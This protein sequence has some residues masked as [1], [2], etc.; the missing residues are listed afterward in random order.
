MLTS[1]ERTQVVDAFA[2]AI[3]VQEHRQLIGV[4]FSTE[5]PQILLSL[6]TGSS[7]P[8]TLATL[9]VETCL[10]SRWATDP[11]L[12]ALLLDY[13]V[14]ARGI[15]ALAVVLQRVRDRVD[16]N[17]SEYGSTWLIGRRPFFDRRTLRERVQR[18]IED[19]GRPILRV[20][21]V[22]DSFGRTYSR[23][24]LEHLEDR[25]TGAVRVVAVELGAGTGPSYRIDDLLDTVASQLGVADPLPPRVSS[26]H[27]RTAARWLLK[28]L[29]SRPGRWLLVLDGFGDKGLHPEVRETIEALAASVP[30]GQYRL[31]IRLVLLDYPYALPGTTPSDI[32]EDALTP[33]AQIGASDIGQ[34]LA[35]WDADRKRLGREGMS[36]GDLVK[37]ATGLLES[38]PAAGR[39]RLEALNAELSKLRE[40]E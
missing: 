6:P 26:D 8:Q 27:S 18:L 20:S 34:C 29:M 4:V 1:A 32:L 21:P 5:A 39:E 7:T 25:A 19:N 31:R 12:L 15:G 10:A 16:P 24:F 13:L 28:Q 37:L 36:A 9:V 14:T 11:A 17:P 33:A 40:L 22:P 38:V 23:Y 30:S 35:D 3:A 2:M